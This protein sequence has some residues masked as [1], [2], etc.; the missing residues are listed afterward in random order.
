M[1]QMP[2]LGT[3]FKR[4]SWPLFLN[5]QAPQPSLIPDIYR[6]FLCRSPLQWVISELACATYGLVA[7]PLYDTLGREALR[8]ICNHC[9]FALRS[10]VH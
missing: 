5:S 7:V 1:N 3:T 4:G 9:E 2:I 6:L 10:E 8:H